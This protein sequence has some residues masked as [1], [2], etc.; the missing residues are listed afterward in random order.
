MGNAYGKISPLSSSFIAKRRTIMIFF[1]K[2]VEA[3][4]EGGGGKILLNFQFGKQMI[5]C[6]IEVYEQ[7]ILNAIDGHILEALIPRWCTHDISRKL[8]MQAT[9]YIERI[10]HE[11]SCFIDFLTS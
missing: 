8:R 4:G 7:N 5:S 6:P 9:K 1:V 2:W 3:E 11:C 10:L